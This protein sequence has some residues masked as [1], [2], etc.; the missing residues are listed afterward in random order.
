MNGKDLKV[1]VKIFEEDYT[2]KINEYND[3]F[4][5][6]EGTYASKYFRKESV[7][8]LEDLE[9]MNFQYLKH[10]KV[11]FD[12]GLDGLNINED[13]IHRIE[14]KYTVDILGD[15]RRFLRKEFKNKS[16]LSIRHKE[17]SRSISITVFK[18]SFLDDVL[19]CALKFINDF[20]FF[21]GESNFKVTFNDNVDMWNNKII[22]NCE[23]VKI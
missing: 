8:G 3:C 12:Y 17:R 6:E 9:S 11:R 20:D 18:D 15:L 16:K 22:L 13:S 21:V 23:L 14:S 5:I 1:D 4:G 7:I 10:N 19:N 2:I